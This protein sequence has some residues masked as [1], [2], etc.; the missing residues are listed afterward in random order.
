MEK[1][2]WLA[3]E[4]DYENEVPASRVSPAY[5]DIGISRF[6][7]QEKEGWICLVLPDGR[8]TPHITFDPFSRQ[9]IYVLIHGSYGVLRS[10]QGWTGDQ[11]VFS[12]LMTMIGINREWR[13][14]WTRSDDRRF[15]FV[16]EERNEDGSWAHIDQWRFQRRG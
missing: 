12:G 9:W 10:S 2:R 16:N 4:W 14:T 7:F 6:S 1:F 3:G 15:S 11:I 13:M 8:E 5:T